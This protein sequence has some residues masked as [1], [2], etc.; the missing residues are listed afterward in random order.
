[1]QRFVRVFVSKSKAVGGVKSKNKHA[2]RLYILWYDFQKQP[3][4]VFY[5]KAILKNFTIF[6]GN[7]Y[8]GVSF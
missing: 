3:L 2:G 8:V 7:T 6:A 1:M 5:K 4:E